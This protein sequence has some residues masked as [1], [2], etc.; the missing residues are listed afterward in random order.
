MYQLY[1][2]PGNANLAPHI[3]LEEIGAEYELVL[4]D[5][6][7]DEHKSPAHLALNPTGRI[8]VLIE[9]DLVLY[10]TAAI[11]LPLADGHAAA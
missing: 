9:G 1:Y 10:E 11:F 5:R 8:P 6:N 2:Y 3:L 4:V 7:K